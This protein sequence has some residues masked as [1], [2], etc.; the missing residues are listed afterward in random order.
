MRTAIHTIYTYLPRAGQDRRML[1][2]ER[3]TTT[4]FSRQNTI[5]CSGVDH[6]ISMHTLDLN[7]EPPVIATAQPLMT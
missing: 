3:T 5:N 2:K 1:Q 7:Y 6:K 4:T